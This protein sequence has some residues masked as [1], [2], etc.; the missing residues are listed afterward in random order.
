MQVAWRSCSGLK[1]E[2]QGQKMSEYNSTPHVVILMAHA[3]GGHRSAALSL[4]EALEGQARVTLL[5][6]L[7]DYTPFPFNRMSEAYGP[8]VNRA[9][10]LYRLVYQLGASRQRVVLAKRA[11]YPLVRQRL[12]RALINAQPDLVISVHPLQTDVPLWLLRR[13]HS[14][15]PF[16]TVVTDPVSPPV[17]WFCPNVDLCIVA[18]EAARACALKAGMDPHKVRVIGLPVRRAF[19]AARDQPKP[20]ARAR[21][22]LDPQRPLLLMTGGGAGIG[23]L[24]P[25]ARAVTRRL[26]LE[27]GRVQ[28][29][30][31]A[32]SNRALQSRLRAETWPLPVVVLGFVEAMAD[33]LAAADLLI[34]KA[35]PG[36]LAEA[37]CVG[38]PVIITGFVPG[39]EEG[40]VA[41]VKESGAGT[42]EPKPERVAALVSEWLRP[43]N[44]ILAEMAARARAMAKPEAAQQIAQAALELIRQP[45]PA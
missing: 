31:I 8:W 40:N 41:W 21:L 34:T 23:R 7:D 39:Q 19:V 10:W 32:G 18:T 35:G 24:V 29:A 17:A 20:A 27:G 11:V 43:G 2:L 45:V 6:L 5:N 14:R 16:V 9:P 30:I 38:V 3:G 15:A 44:P 42:F 26:A 37:A 13:A 28:V 1:P 25:L 33:W 12:A 36:T 4:A 22:G